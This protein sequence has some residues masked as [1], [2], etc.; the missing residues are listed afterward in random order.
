MSLQLI[1][2]RHAKSAWDDPTL[3]DHDR[4]LNHR[5]C[6]SADALGDWVRSTDLHPDLVLCS[7][8][9][10]TQETFARLRLDVPL[11]LSAA[12]YLA[13]E[14]LMMDLIQAQPVR[15]LMMIGHNPGIAELARLLV[16][17][18]PPHRRFRDYPTGATTV[19]QF[20]ASD[21]GQVRFGTGR[22]EH[23]VIPADLLDQSPRQ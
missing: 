10:R 1:L 6:D 20:D 19:I 12:L 2:M 22:V 11:R 14:D 16:R 18:A 4:V 9:K 13:S 7:T 5:G 15:N 3:D 23:F 17:K 8:A 21:W